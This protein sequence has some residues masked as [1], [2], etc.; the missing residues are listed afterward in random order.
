MWKTNFSDAINS[1]INRD[2]PFEPQ[3]KPHYLRSTWFAYLICVLQIPHLFWAF[4]VVDPV[5]T[6]QWE[7]FVRNKESLR[8]EEPQQGPSGLVGQRRTLIE[9]PDDSDQII[10]ECWINCGL[11]Q[12]CSDLLSRILCWAWR[13]CC[14]PRFP[15][16]VQTYVLKVSWRLNVWMW[17]CVSVSVGV[18]T[19]LGWNLY[20]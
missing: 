16:T 13:R 4:A 9:T 2:K 11:G 6:S 7:T 8:E 10:W 19:S 3:D 14:V 1:K 12:W 15:P 18:S 5:Q 17:V 20:S